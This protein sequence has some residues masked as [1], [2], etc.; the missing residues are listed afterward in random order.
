MNSNTTTIDP[1]F[2]PI[3]LERATE[4]EAL[5]NRAGRDNSVLV[6]DPDQGVQGV[7]RPA[8]ISP[9]EGTVGISRFRTYFLNDDLTQ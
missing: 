6:V 4:L 5:I 1:S 3:D 9:D 2:A 7:R 8:D